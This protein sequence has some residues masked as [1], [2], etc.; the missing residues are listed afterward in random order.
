MAQPETLAPIA[1]ES[2][3]RPASLWPDSTQAQ[4]MRST[5]FAATRFDPLHDQVTQ[6]EERLAAHFD[7]CRSGLALRLVLAILLGVAASGAVVAPNAA[8]WWQRLPV[9]VF[10]ALAATLLWLPT[11]CACRRRLPRWPEAGQWAFVL[12]LGA[13]SA[14]AGWALLLPLDLAD[15]TVWRG[16]TAAVAGA[17]MAGALWSWLAL[18]ARGAEPALAAARLAELQSRIRPHFLFNALNTA[19]ALVRADPAR[20]ERVLEDLA[21]LFRAALA[22]AGSAVTLDQ[23][24]ELARRYLA[25]EQVRFGRR[26]ELTWELDPAAAAARLPPLVLQPLVENAVRHGVEP[27]ARGARVVVH[28]QAA[29]GMATVWVTNTT[30][31]ESRPGA[32]IAL[33]NVRERLRLLH[34]VAGGLETWR[35]DGLFHARITVPL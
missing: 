1:D 15:A 20:A 19:L 32:G 31:G 25:I 24:I 33:H 6:A 18:R 13:G 17:A 35:E 14:L 12:G 23:E 2:P 4:P 29:G 16:L 9:L 30:A 8:L 10:V 34:D 7:I 26:L 21:E 5:G 3:S 22:E 28:T 11:V 27:S